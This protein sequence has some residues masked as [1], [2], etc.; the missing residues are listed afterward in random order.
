[1]IEIVTIATPDQRELLA[2]FH[3]GIYW[4]EFAA[5][6]EPLAAWEHALWGGDPGYELTIRLALADREIVG[7]VAFE[8]YPRCG[9]GLV[10][11]VVVAPAARRDG[12]GKR[13]RSEAAATLFAAGAPAVFG[14]IND[15]RHG[16]HHESLDDTRRRLARNQ[17]WGSRVVDVRY[18]Q[19]ALGPGLARDRGLCLL[20]LAG[21]EPLP[22]T[23]PGAI[24]RDFIAELY[25]VT[26]R[27]AP[28]AEL[29]ELL[30]QIPDTVRLVE[31][32]G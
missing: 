24:V 5:Q 15:P 3:R 12:L 26:E 19:P 14:E 28:D 8:R 13:L 31:L 30:A 17:R 25:A 1:M 22:P 32:A 29:V 23:M 2:R 4:D 21:A 6:H 20:A 27:R 9:C 10:T 11:Y 16:P 18:I 7:G